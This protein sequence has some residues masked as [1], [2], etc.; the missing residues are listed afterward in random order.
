[1]TSEAVAQAARAFVEWHQKGQPGT[2]GTLY[3]MTYAAQEA[4][5]IEWDRRLEALVE[6]VGKEL[7]EDPDA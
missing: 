1:M 4:W 6:A 2:P 3:P 5:H 7:R